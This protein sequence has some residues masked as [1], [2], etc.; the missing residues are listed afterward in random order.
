MSTSPLTSKGIRNQRRNVDFFNIT[1]AILVALLTLMAIGCGCCRGPL[2][3]FSARNRPP[4]WQSIDP[5]RG[6]YQILRRITHCGVCN[7]DA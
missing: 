1:V 2:T 5:L 7:R 6:M 3:I 4:K